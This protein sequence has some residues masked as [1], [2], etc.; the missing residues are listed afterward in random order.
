MFTSQINRGWRRQGGPN[1]AA[2]AGI[3][4]FDRY[5]ARMLTPLAVNAD[6]LKLPEGTVLAREGSRARQV[7]GVVAG[8]VGAGRGGRPIGVLGPGTWIGTTELL[9]DR[10]HGLSFVAGE[11]LEVL[12]LTA[13]AFRWAA[14]TLP[15]LGAQCALAQW[16]AQQAA[17]PAPGG[18]SRS[19]LIG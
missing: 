3:P 7:V 14:S 18:Y 17:D 12:V 2:L 11:G 15:G 16:R 1:V 9:E 6:R 19:G 8:T 10:P 5:P 4:P 13:P